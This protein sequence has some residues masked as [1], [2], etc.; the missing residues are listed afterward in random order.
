MFSVV[1]RLSSPV[2][3]IGLGGFS[4]SSHSSSTIPYSAELAS[5]EGSNCN[6]V[7]FGAMISRS[8]SHMTTIIQDFTLVALTSTITSHPVGLLLRVA[9]LSHLT[10]PTTYALDSS[11]S[12]QLEVIFGYGNYLCFVHL[13]KNE[14]IIS[15][16]SLDRVE[17]D[18]L[19]RGNQ[20]RS[21][22]VQTSALSSV[23]V[24]V[25]G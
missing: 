23:L 2:F 6:N 7:T 19:V 21:S 5:K 14:I 8:G 18:W 15:R 17:F 1:S 11:L 10:Y 24:R 9:V 12:T 20:T 25:T 13:S 16:V 22:L 3:L 4:P